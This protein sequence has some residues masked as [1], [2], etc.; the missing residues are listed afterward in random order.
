MKKIE[1]ERL[2]DN[3]KLYTNLI[4]GFVLNNPWHVD[5]DFWVKKKA[6]TLLKISRLEKP[7]RK[8]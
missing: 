4:D 7:R 3:L 1:K 6:Q 2:I 5:Y 8:K